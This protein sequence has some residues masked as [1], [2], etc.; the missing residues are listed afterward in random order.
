MYA[1]GGNA[2][3]FGWWIW[4]DQIS[5]PK[6]TNVIAAVGTKLSLEKKTS[7][8]SGCAGENPEDEHD[9]TE[10][11][12]FTLQLGNH[13]PTDLIIRIFENTQSTEKNVKNQLCA[14]LV[15]I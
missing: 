1:I 2:M 14:F 13:F 4:G 8:K 12:Q 5:S 3:N 15:S 10:L 7:N 11:L 9:Q 6:S